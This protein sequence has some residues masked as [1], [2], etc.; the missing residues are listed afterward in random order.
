MNSRFELEILGGNT[1]SKSNLDPVVST[2][3]K[4][5][6][7][8]AEEKFGQKIKQILKNT[9]GHDSFRDGQRSVVFAALAGL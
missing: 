8:E 5:S 6:I 2:R 9:F 4:I 7:L 3:K 1:K